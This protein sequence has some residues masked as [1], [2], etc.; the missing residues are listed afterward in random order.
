MTID[1]TFWAAI[2]FF[3]FLGV[4]IY[5]KIPQKIKTVLEENI[6]SIRSQINEAEKLK[7]EAKNIL[8]EHE[9][10]ISNSKIE[11]TS[12]I[13]KANEESDKNVI[14][15]N[16]EF[17]NLMENRKKNA[18]ERIKQMKKQALKDIKNASI[19]IA[20]QSVEKLLKNSLD[21]TKLDKIYLSSI[22]ETK[23]AL[24]KKSS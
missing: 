12:M 20:I 24:K 1:A 2:S 10:K 6:S 14:K 3:I 16:K 7:E 11:V 9:K 15:T 21:K 22:H 13:S 5:F 23:L 17:H 8:S 18:D 4:L 19:K